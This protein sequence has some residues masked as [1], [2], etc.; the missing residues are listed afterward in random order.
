MSR[1][2]TVAPTGPASTESTATGA[3][4]GLRERKKQR[5]RQVIQEVAYRLIETTGYESTTIEQIAAAAEVSPSTVF[6]YFPSKEHIVLRSDYATSSAELLR[7]RPLDEPPLVALRAAVTGTM[8]L[9]QEDFSAEYPWKMALVREVP[10]VRAQMHAAQ[11]R[12]VE[13]LSAALAE[14]TGR[15]QDDLELKVLV[16]ALMGGLHQALLDWGDHGQQGDLPDTIDR[17]LAALDQ[18][19]TL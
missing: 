2:P 3:A 1:A 12:L 7:A 17:A 11:D 10:A 15:P 16:G 4:P 5:T 14:R 8:R 6:R 18:G 13:V 19:L 9:F